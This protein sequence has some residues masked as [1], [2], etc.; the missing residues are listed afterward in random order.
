M[1]CEIRVS[2]SKKFQITIP[3]EVRGDLNIQKGDKLFL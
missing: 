2:V 1:A 3:T